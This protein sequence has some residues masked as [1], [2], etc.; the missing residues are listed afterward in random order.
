YLP[1]Y[2][3]T[4]LSSGR[5]AVAVW[6]VIT[7]DRLGPLVRI[8]GRFNAS[9]Y[10]N[11]IDEELMPYALDGPFPDGAYLLQH[12]RS[13]VHTARRVDA[14]LEDRGVCQLPWPPNGADM[15]PIENVW[16][17]MKTRLASQN[18]GSATADALWSAISQE[19]EALRE[20][21]EIV[22]SLYDSMPRRLEE[23]ISVDGNFTGR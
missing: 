11:I 16:G 5:C 2:V 22:A 21:T 13:P 6:G 1:S 15:N 4:V 20:H 18:L 14:L 19:W 17:L 9:S 12:D 3:Q 23:V 7:K 8:E 10:C